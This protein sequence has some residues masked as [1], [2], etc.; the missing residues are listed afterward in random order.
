[1]E[2]GRML[3]KSAQD[4]MPIDLG[5]SLSKQAD[6]ASELN[7]DQYQCSDCRFAGHEGKFVGGRCPECGGKSAS[8]V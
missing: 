7:G 8:K 3:T 4:A 2:V 1:M 5:W 6:D